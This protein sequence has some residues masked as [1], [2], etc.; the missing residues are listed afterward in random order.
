[1]NQYEKDLEFI[2]QFVLSHGPTVRTAMDAL[3]CSKK[4]SCIKKKV[5]LH[6]DTGNAEAREA[7]KL[8][9]S[10][11][12]EGLFPN[13]TPVKKQEDLVWMANDEDGIFFAYRVIAVDHRTHVL[14]IGDIES[15]K[16]IIG[17]LREMEES[18]G[19]IKIKRLFA[20]PNRRLDMTSIAIK[21]SEVDDDIYRTLYPTFEKTPREF[22]DGYMASDSP[23]VFLMGSPGTGKTSYLKY[24]LAESPKDEPKFLI[25]SSAVLNSPE[26]FNYL[27]DTPG[28]GIL[29]IEDADNFLGKREGG[30]TQMTELLNMTSGLGQAS[31]KIVITTNLPQLS[32]VDEALL[33]NGRT[34]A[35]MEFKP[36]TSDEA[37]AVRE[38]L[39]LPPA[40]FNE[41]ET[42]TLAETVAPILTQT[43]DTVKTKD[44]GFLAS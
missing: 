20:Q 17:L 25:D 26:L 3:F 10:N 24:L 6:L 27:R 7:R 39:G 1:M 19:I 18:Y 31:L 42:Y 2:K 16:K 22:L 43:T 4:T 12:I 14:L 21:Q 38:V 32:S 11:S 29:V 28:G 33:R 44:F 5:S 37:V 34:Y 35:I 8:E 30:N 15:G 40:H 13:H 41:D 23:I 9:I 36:Y